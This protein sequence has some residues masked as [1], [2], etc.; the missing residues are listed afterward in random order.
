MLRTIFLAGLLFISCA[1]VHAYSVV[2]APGST[3]VVNRIDALA[4][5]ELSGTYDVIFSSDN[6][7]TVQATGGYLIYDQLL[8]ASTAHGVMSEIITVLNTTTA[9]KVGSGTG[10]PQG[11]FFLP[12]ADDTTANHALTSRGRY[13]GASGPWTDD[14]GFSVS[15]STADNT[16]FVTVSLVQAVPLPAALPLLLSGLG[17][18]GLLARRRRTG[19]G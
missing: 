12:Y 5:N 9:S 3:T 18:L 10:I 14:G 15:I 13:L 2:Y 16:G 7:N 19:N 1:S 11:T 17:G 4:I 8:G 6:F